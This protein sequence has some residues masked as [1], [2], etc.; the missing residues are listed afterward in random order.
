M[1]SAWGWG[2]GCPRPGCPLS[3]THIPGQKALPCLPVG[4]PFCYA[5]AW[6]C[7]SAEAALSS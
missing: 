5:F 7:L 1:A 2:W 3:H 4:Q 6:S